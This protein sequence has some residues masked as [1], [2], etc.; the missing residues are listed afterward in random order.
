MVSGAS[1]GLAFD[2][3]ADRVIAVDENGDV[4]DGD[5]MLAIAAVD[6]HDRGLLNGDAVVATVMSNLGLRRAL[7]PYG[8]E[9]IE[10]PVGDRNVLDELERRDLTIGGEQSGHV[11]NTAHSTTGDGTLTGIL[12]LDTMVRRRRSLS[13]L[14][15]VMVRVPQVLRNVAVG[16]PAALNADAA[17][18][19]RVRDVDDDL[20]DDGRVLVRQSGTE[21]VVRVMVE[22]GDT[23]DAEAAAERLVELVEHAARRSAPA[24]P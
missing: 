9:L 20:G 6:L 24:T 7:M 19:S 16:D 10:T 2:G 8:I 15:S 14:A 23:T 22:A 3:D 13:E 18:W 4:V 1:A 21:P 12:L 17:F 5:Q 11:I